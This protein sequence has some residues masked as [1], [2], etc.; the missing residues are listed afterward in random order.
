MLQAAIRKLRTDYLTLAAAVLAIVITGALLAHPVA[1]MNYSAGTYGSCQYNTCGISLTT[2]GSISVNVTPSV[3]A[4]TCTVSND[5]VTVTTNA[6]TGYTV[7][8]TD[9]DTA[10]GLVGPSTIT[11]SPGTPTAPVLLTANTW[12]YRVDGIAA[13]GAGPTTALSSVSIPTQT[14]AGVPLSSGTPGAIRTTNVVDGSTVNTSVWYGV[15]VNN[16]LTSGAYTDSVTYTAVI[17]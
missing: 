1:G 2:S 8:L 4:T 11:A 6:S 14:Y 16:S 3:G 15:C 9:T 5:I 13:F 10:N 17:N 7:T 12:G